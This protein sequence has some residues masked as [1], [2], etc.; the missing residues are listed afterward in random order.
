MNTLECLVTLGFAAI[1]CL[2]FL[3]IVSNGRLGMVKASDEITRRETEVASPP[4]T[5]SQ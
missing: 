2:S 3:H 1:A 4:Q 5:Q